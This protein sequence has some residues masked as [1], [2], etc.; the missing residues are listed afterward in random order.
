MKNSIAILG[1]GAM[2]QLIFNDLSKTYKGKIF[3]LGRNVKKLKKIANGKAG[4]RNADVNNIKSMIKAFKGIDVVI[5]AVHHEYNLN[6]MNACLK[7]KSNYLDLGGLFHY[8]KK[9]LK[10]SKKFKKAGLTAILGIG[11][12]PG[13]TNVLAGYGAKL[14][15]SLDNVEIKIGNIDKSAYK[16]NSPLSNTYSI[17]TILEEFSWKPAV[18]VNG[19]MRF[20]QPVSDREEYPFPKPVGSK[21]VQS[22]I[23]SELATL[24]HSLRANNVSFK[25]AFDDDF[26]SKIL[27]L[28]ELGFLS[29]EKAKEN[30]TKN[31]TLEILKML[32]SAIPEKIDQYEIIR[33]ILEGEKSWAKKI[34]T[35]DAHTKGE[36][37]TVDKDTAV[38]ASIAAQMISDGTI[39]KKGAFPPELIV[40]EKKFFEELAKRKIYIFLNQKVKL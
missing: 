38:P 17:Q 26:V 7:S 39:A 24:P 28:K 18:F 31:I 33:V 1:L 30:K 25:I 5:H 37:E 34:I 40:P 21:K 14:L 35:L 10:L 3:L 20:I 9:Q 11:A 13:I 2:G 23:H 29:E 16:Q 8:T 19:K 4:V 12:S 22:T 36:N 32:P 15:D 6:V 27:K